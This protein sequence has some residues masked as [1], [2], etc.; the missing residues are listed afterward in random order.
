MPFEYVADPKIMSVIPHSTILRF[1][2]VQ[3]TEAHFALYYE[4]PPV[5]KEFKSS[6]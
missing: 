5:T 4:C 3:E 6:K 2:F 1:V